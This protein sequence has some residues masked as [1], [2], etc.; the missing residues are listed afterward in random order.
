MKRIISL[1]LVVAMLMTST[2]TVFAKGKAEQG[3][4]RYQNEFKAAAL[5]D[6]GL[7][8]GRSSKVYYPDLGTGATRAEAI[9][10]IGEALGWASDTNA[11]TGFKPSLTKV[12][13]YSDVP[14]WAA[15]YVDYAIR[16]N[17][18]KGIGH[19]KFGANLPVNSRMMYTWYARALFYTED[20]WNNMQLLVKL[21]FLTAE[22]YA[23]LDKLSPST[24]DALAG[25]MFNSL[26]WKF[27]GS[28]KKLIQRLVQ[29]MW[30]NRDKAE[31][32]GLLEPDKT[33]MTWTL[34]TVSSKTLQATFSQTVDGTTVNTDAF[35]VTLKRGDATTTL[36][37]SGTDAAFS[38]STSGKV[39]TLAFASAFLNGDIVTVTPATTIESVSDAKAD[40][41]AK[42]VTILDTVK[43]ALVDVVA[44]SNTQIRFVF[45]ESIGTTAVD[46]LAKIQL[47]QGSVT[48]LP[49]S[50]TTSAVF[51]KLNTELTLTL[52]T[53]L[54]NGRWDVKVLAGVLDEA[55]PSNASVEAT[56]FITLGTDSVA[57]SV[58]RVDVL[59]YNKILVTF[60]EAVKPSIGKLTVIDGLHDTEY[61]LPATLTNDGKTAELTLVPVLPNYADTQFMYLKYE[62]IKDLSDNTKS[63]YSV[64][65][66]KAPEDTDDPDATFGT[67]FATRD[68]VKG[69]EIVIDLDEPVQ[70]VTAADYTLTGKSAADAV[71][72]LTPTLTVN[73]A[74]TQAIVFVKESE[75]AEGIN[76]L[77]LTLK[78]TIKDLSVNQNPLV[79]DPYVV[80]VV[81]DTTAPTAAVSKFDEATKSFTITFSE[82]V[83]T[84]TSAQ[85]AL[86]TSS[87]S[88]SVA[89][90]FSVNV[91]QTVV[92]VTAVTAPV[93]DDF[94]L[95]LTLSDTIVD[96]SY[97]ANPL[98][99]LSRSF[100]VV[101]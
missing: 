88:I 62:G 74:N 90:T 71:L 97:N 35:Q 70:G 21:G 50:P 24:R 1:V 18:T 92:T 91:G 3:N 69:F 4:G 25:I 79:Q 84:F 49:T 26:N 86:T 80:E 37:N 19:G 47:T 95:K 53:P 7:F 57:P 82:P 44:V 63:T 77:T 11:T 33:T 34:K 83:A 6:M 2:A 94:P 14:D 58:T 81:K 96:K 67:R 42:Q 27:K 29:L 28:D 30:V 64:F 13:G 45:S 89:T 55:N 38:V 60:S 52:P 8:K 65:E 59:A 100:D 99:V 93:A 9:K 31:D 43:P 39:V 17:I 76:T 68:T 23:E 36:D 101:K 87:S 46:M 10:M 22:Q 12:E 75:L 61:S 51:S 41:S 15:P 40:G 48:L 85:Y 5:Y 32:N 20:I 66:F 98:A 54:G 16:H 73:A 78:E 72:T 56:D